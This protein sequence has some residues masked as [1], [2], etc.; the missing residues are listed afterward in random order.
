MS[1]QESVEYL[2]ST[3]N[4]Q[5]Y[6]KA[7]FNGL[8]C[9][10]DYR[11]AFVAKFFKDQNYQAITIDFN[12]FNHIGSADMDWETFID[13]KIASALQQCPEHE[14]PI[15]VFENF[16][17]IQNAGQQSYIKMLIE[18]KELFK[19]KTRE[20]ESEQFIPLFFSSCYYYD[21]GISGRFPSQITWYITNANIRD[22]KNLE[23]IHDNISQQN[24]LNYARIRAEEDQMYENQFNDD[25]PDSPGHIG[26][27]GSMQDIGEEKKKKNYLSGC[28]F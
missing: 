16:H 23:A 21:Y 7:W 17:H 22:S 5:S 24:E 26:Y 13:T 14:K 19:A 11:D 8:V 1:L 4:K 6:N 15:I 18:L 2:E 12:E 10:H 20:S 25:I 9:E 28:P 3:L 27:D